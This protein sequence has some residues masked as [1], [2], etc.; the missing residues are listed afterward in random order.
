MPRLLDERVA[1]VALDQHPDSSFI[2]K[3][4]GPTMWSRPRSRSQP[5]AASSRAGDR[6]G[7]LLHLQEAEHPPVVALEVVERVVDLGADPTH[8]SAVAPGE[9]QLGVGVLEVG[10]EVPAEEEPPLEPQRGNPLLA[11]SVVEGE[12]R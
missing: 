12:G 6:L 9:E 4:I 10:V 8:D 1:V 5:A 11:G 7:A 2:V 3:S